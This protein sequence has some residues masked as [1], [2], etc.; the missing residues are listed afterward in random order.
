MKKGVKRLS[1]VF[2]RLF[3]CLFLPFRLDMSKKGVSLRQTGDCGLFDPVRFL[4]GKTVVPGKVNTPPDV[5]A[6]PF[7][8]GL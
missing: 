1:M 6:L 7:I 3:F 4:F 2:L 5:L 8:Y